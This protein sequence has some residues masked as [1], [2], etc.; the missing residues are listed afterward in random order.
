MERYRRALAQ[1]MA[2]QQPM[3]MATGGLTQSDYDTFVSDVYANVVAYYGDNIDGANQYIADRIRESIAGFADAGIDPDMGMLKNAIESIGGGTYGQD[4][5]QLDNVLYFADQTLEPLG[6]DL[7]TYTPI[8]LEPEPEPEPEPPVSGPTIGG[9]GDNIDIGGGD[10]PVTI[11]DGSDVTVDVPAPE[12]EPLVLTQNDYDT[13]TQSVFDRAVAGQITPEQ[14]IEEI[15]SGFTA[16][17][18]QGYN[19]EA[20]KLISSVNTVWSNSSTGEDVP[21]EINNALFALDQILEPQGL[22]IGTYSLIEPPPPE[23]PPPPPEEPVIPT[24]TTSLQG[25]TDTVLALTQ[26]AQTTGDYTALNQFLQDEGITEFGLRQIFPDITD[27]DFQL[28][29]DAGATPFG[30]AQPVVEE[31]VVPTVGDIPADFY[32]GFQTYYNSLDPETRGSLSSELEDYVAGNLDVGSVLAS[33][34]A[35]DYE[36]GG[37]YGGAFAPEVYDPGLPFFGYRTP[38]STGVNVRAPF[39]QYTLSQAEADRSA[40]APRDVATFQ[41][42]AFGRFSPLER[43]SAIRDVVSTIGLDASDLPER[44]MEFGV[45]PEELSSAVGLPLTSLPAGI[46]GVTG[47]DT[48]TIPGTVAPTFVPQIR[49]ITPLSGVSGLPSLTAPTLPTYNPIS[50]AATPLE[51]AQATIDAMNAPAES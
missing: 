22:D 11:G 16:L 3:K 31:P 8:T 43:E 41:Q 18:D 27:Q 32:Q 46:Q 34:N 25:V 39:G 13:Y 35:Q 33:A 36:F 29:L 42:E 24:D 26:Q 5:T 45:T 12:P 48:R 6:Y 40:I 47:F 44:M 10:S 17:Q 14:I 50:F 30:Y 38:E 51:V 2:E 9:G 23:E 15:S 21:T 20:D 19:V 49:D 7:G 28:V 4:R 1:Y 37:G